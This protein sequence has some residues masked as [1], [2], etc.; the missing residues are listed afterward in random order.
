MSKSFYQ[1]VVFACLMLMTGVQLFAQ[2]EPDKIEKIY[3]HEL[4]EQEKV[5]FHLVGKDFLETDPPPGVVTTSQ[6]SITW[7]AF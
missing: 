3:T 4:S 1:I 7:K 5:N 2:I 6:S